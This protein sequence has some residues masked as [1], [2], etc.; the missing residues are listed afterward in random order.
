MTAEPLILVHQMAKVAS[1][2]WREAARPALEFAHPGPLHVHYLAPANLAVI[3]TILH[4][5]ARAN[6]IANPLIVRQMG[7]KGRAT[8]T[9]V[10][11]SRHENCQIRVITGMRDPVARSISLVGFLADFVGHSTRALGARQGATA[12]AV[13]HFLS[14]TWDAVLTGTVPAGNFER[15]ACWMTGAYRSWFDEE[16]AGVHGLDVFATRFSPD[17]GAQAVLG[18]AAWALAYRMEDMAADSPKRAK[19]LAQAASFLSL[20][21]ISLPELNTAA[22]RRSRG[23]SEEVQASFHLPSDWLNSIYAAPTVRHFYPA[24]E[25]GAFKARWS[26]GGAVEA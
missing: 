26:G 19:L 18:D 12:E 6:T 4:A 24:A 14:E 21:T 1:L 20:Q 7:R 10:A 15:L 13:V 17:D 16:L 5:E 23:L 8:A 11:A 3:E 9:A 25:I 22:T 2:A